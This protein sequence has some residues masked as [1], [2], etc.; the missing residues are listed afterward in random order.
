MY[1]LEAT[2]DEPMG[3]E[4]TRAAWRHGRQRSVEEEGWSSEKVRT[5]DAL[6]QTGDEGRGKLRKA[7]GSC[8]QAQIRGCPN[9]GTR[10]EQSRHP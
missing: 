2:V 3:F 8:K 10:R 7:S 6:A 4:W 5:V 9:G 1:V